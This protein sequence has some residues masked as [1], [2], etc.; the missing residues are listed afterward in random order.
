MIYLMSQ[1]ATLADTL[2]YESVYAIEQ[3]L[4]S[5]VNRKFVEKTAQTSTPKD[6][7]NNEKEPLPSEDRYRVIENKRANLEYYKN[8]SISFFV[9]AA[10]TALAILGKDAFQFSASDLHSGYKFLQD[11]FKTNLPLMWIKHPNIISEKP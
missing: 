4:E 1:K 11:F 2:L 8:N 7:E 3:A 9:P 10:Y 6:V 5:Y